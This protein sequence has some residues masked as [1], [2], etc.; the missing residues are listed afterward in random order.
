MQT[1]RIGNWLQIAGNLGLIAGLI[2]VAYQINQTA[3]ITKDRVYFDR[4]TAWMD[5]SNALLGEQPADVLGKA[6]TNPEQLTPGEIVSLQT[7]LSLR[8]D[9]W[10]RI[11]SLGQRGIIDES[12][13]RA[14]IDRNHPEFSAGMLG[15]FSTP[16][17]RAYWDIRRKEMRDQEMVEA[18]DL[19][20]AEEPIRDHWQYEEYRR[21]IQRY[22]ELASQP[23]T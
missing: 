7:Y 9:Y 23:Q 18:I 19:A 6:H 13:W 3:D 8:L 4:W 12:D 20:L 1:E 15:Q 10:R 11:K 2:L 17:G 16:A 22:Q 5:T 21:A 14:G